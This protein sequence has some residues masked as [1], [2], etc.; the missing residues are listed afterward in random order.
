MKILRI[1]LRNIASLAG[2]HTVD[3]TKPPLANAGLFSISG[4]TG[5]GKSTL[6]D[7]LCLAL[8][9]ETPRL[10]LV[11]GAAAMK[12]AE[13]SVQQDD[14]RNLLRHG[15]GE[16]YAE[17]AFL[18]VDGGEYTARWMTRRARGR[19]EGNLR[20]SEHSLFRGNIYAGENGELAV[21]GTATEVK[22][23][24][25]AKVGLSF[26]Q[27]RRAVLLAQGDFATFL[28][29]KDTERAEILQALTGTE[30]FE[31]I[32]KAIFERTKLEEAKL[33]GLQLKLGAAV[34]L[35]Q[36]ARAE[37]LEE[38]RIAEELCENLKRQ[39]AERSKQE[40]WFAVEAARQSEL[41][42]AHARVR[43][44]L[45][46]VES[47]APRARELQ[48]V[49]SAS[50]EARP[51]RQTEQEAESKL[52]SALQRSNVLREEE[53]KLT[54]ALE[55]AKR[56]H[57][58]AS[59]TLR[60]ALTAQKAAVGDLARARAL[61]AELNPLREALAVA[62]KEH[63]GA[64]E[65]FSKAEKELSRLKGELE[66]LKDRKRNLQKKVAELSHFEPF[67]PEVGLWMERFKA[68]AKL[69]KKTQSA[70]RLRE[71]SRNEA[72][73]ALKN[74]QELSLTLP[75]L[76]EQRNAAE[77]RL[78]EALQ[79]AESFNA[80]EI[81]SQRRNV[82]DLREALAD[83][84]SHLE[85][86]KRAFQE[87]SEREASLQ[88]LEAQIILDGAVQEELRKVKIPAAQAFL[89]SAQESLRLA[90]A[91]ASEQ[92][93][94]LRQAL[95]QG[96]ACPVCG[97]CEHPNANVDN[98]VETKMLAALRKGMREKELI[99]QQF[100]ADLSGL[101]PV[102]SERKKQAVETRR[103]LASVAA[104]IHELGAYT[105]ALSEC[106]AVW[107]ML[108]EQRDA[109]LKR[110]EEQAGELLKALDQRDEERIRAEKEARVLQLDFDRKQNTL[111][112]AESSEKEARN[113]ND[114]AVLA[115]SK[116]E[117]ELATLEFELA[118]AL[119]EIRPVLEA[120]K[121]GEEKHSDQDFEIEL[122]DYEEDREAY[123]DWFE[124]GA[125]EWN[126]Y[127]P[128]LATLGLA[129]ASKLEQLGPLSETREEAQRSLQ[130]RAEAQLK[131]LCRVEEKEERRSKLL[132][133]ISVDAFE[134]KITEDLET[135]SS[136][137]AKAR[138]KLMEGEQALGS[139][140]TLLEEH[141]K[142]VA[143]LEADLIRS[144]A[145]MDTWLSEF[146][147]CEGY[148]LIREE[149][150]VWLGRGVRWVESERKSLNEAQEK[151]ATARGH[152]SALRQQLDEHIQARNGTDNLETVKSESTRL[153]AEV[154]S[155][156][157]VTQAKRLVSAGDDER[158]RE[159]GELK[160]EL[161]TQAKRAFPWQ[162]LNSLIGSADG[163]KFRNIAQQWTL[164]IL[165]KHANAQLNLL[166]GRY[167]LERLRDSLNLIITDLEMGWQ[168]SVHS[169][170]GGESFLVSLGLALGLASLT[171]SRLL[172]ESLFIDEG[173]GSLD[174]ETL[175]VALN[176]LS[177]LESQ[178][179]KVGVISHVSELVDAIPV[180]VRVV[181]GIGGASRIVV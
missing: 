46:Q 180:Q 157:E 20:P 34:P 15:C 110:R 81:L 9:D 175:R 145:E 74:L 73:R 118:S 132:G 159:S 66:Q 17:V 51:R 142:N 102:L 126:L 114:N 144:K 16:G 26:D 36:E 72:A 115:C 75:A 28:K 93:L 69:L 97:S 60:E 163:A 77:Q 5:S 99:L 176:A 168:R 122:Y 38:I 173:F 1:S 125:K 146:V 113:V 91:A 166:S 162:K 79:K 48:W 109:E 153:A 42:I 149:L 95:L 123:C 45:D 6:L 31:K 86:Q 49:Q 108:G 96:E 107:R 130:A 40:E 137:E 158:S 52:Q 18:G 165:I 169:L 12:D 89:D 104:R 112:A 82:L 117:A 136:G 55:I 43:E 71:A 100:K 19:S 121:P 53:H 133:G 164:E 21:A 124:R 94:V 32:S 154:A 47:D 116:A 37:V 4:Q 156:I 33:S 150:D 70:R 2:N 67:S 13:G 23:A 172:I 152:E 14:V 138:Q 139:Q 119:E 78:G 98:T 8:F 160:M 35:S 174:S 59:A 84:K 106:A 143:S 3:F 90:E 39:L 68:E 50:I 54:G 11:K 105:P 147:L 140:R 57:E 87:Q 92:A 22:K 128:Q 30:R 65:A 179:R 83:L 155:V 88:M 135:A 56:L 177:H 27:F 167:R 25:V 61:D 111:A 64:K 101:E 131:A 148:T 44:C 129:E 85:N 62:D 29:A 171:S 103:A 80:E 170:S 63:L 181:R 178:G 127:S 161:E 141:T 120:L 76:R 151:L 134:R 7:A 10:A 58:A 24:I 41:S